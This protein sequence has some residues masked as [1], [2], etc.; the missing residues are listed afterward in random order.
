MNLLPYNHQNVLNVNMHSVKFNLHQLTCREDSNEAQQ[1][2][3]AKQTKQALFAPRHL[4]LI[5]IWL[6]LTP[7]VVIVPVSN[8]K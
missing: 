3:Q 6:H 1:T 7:G 5:A 8:R 2:Q 4:H